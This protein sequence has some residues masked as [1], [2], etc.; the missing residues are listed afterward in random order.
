[1]ILSI[2]GY[3]SKVFR[4]LN[5][6]TPVLL[7]LLNADQ[8]T[9]HLHDR[10]IHR[11]YYA[12]NLTTLYLDTFYITLTTSTA[13]CMRSHDPKSPASTAVKHGHGWAI[14]STLYSPSAVPILSCSPIMHSNSS[15]PTPPDTSAAPERR[16]EQRLSSDTSRTQLRNDRDRR[17]MAQ[18]NRQRALRSKADGNNTQDL[19]VPGDGEDMDSVKRKDIELKVAGPKFENDSPAVQADPDKTSRSATDMLSQILTRCPNPPLPSS[20]ESRPSEQPAPTEPRISAYSVMRSDPRTHGGC[21][22]HPRNYW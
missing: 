1:M 14:N 10:L 22:D 3:G 20:L 5:E 11:T 8:T 18:R 4:E 12:D 13:G 19:I 21:Y 17:W 15:A 9:E 7:S 16:Q 2:A 6:R